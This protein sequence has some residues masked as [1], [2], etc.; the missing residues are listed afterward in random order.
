MTI[1]NPY[2]CHPLL[3]KGGPHIESRSNQRSRARENL[4]DEADDYMQERQADANIESVLKADE[5]SD[6][7]GG[8]RQ[9]KQA[10]NKGDYKS[11]FLFTLVA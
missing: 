8:I 7:P 5:E 4:L 2:A 1:R 3:R 6:H 9:S 11:P 10:Q